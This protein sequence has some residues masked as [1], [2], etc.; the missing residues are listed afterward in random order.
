M[1]DKI[2]AKY[3]LHEYRELLADANT[4]LILAKAH[5]KQLEC[6]IR[7]KDNEI[8]ELKNQVEYLKERAGDYN[9]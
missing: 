8:R 1:S 7:N 6:S 4:E 3:I 2:D 5:N 9:G